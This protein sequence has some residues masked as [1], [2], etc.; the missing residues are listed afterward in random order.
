[1]TDKAHFK[2]LQQL[3]D[4]IRCLNSALL[5][6]EGPSNIYAP[7]AEKI[8]EITREL[9]EYPTRTK[10]YDKRIKYRGPEGIPD[11]IY[12]NHQDLSPVS[13]PSNPVSPY[14]N[15]EMAGE[16]HVSGIARFSSIYEGPPGFVHGGY[17]AAVI[18]ETLGKVQAQTDNP[19]MTSN[20]LI[21]YI[22]PCP[23]NLEYSL[24]GRIIKVEGRRIFTKAS[25]TLNGKIM[26]A[27]KAT[28]VA[29]V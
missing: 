26:A 22:R 7:L 16:Y 27:A 12:G 19:G 11:I 18:D 13:G 29:P 6:H 15:L 5:G 21:Q 3:A 28:F 17:I 8:D 14:V 1:M 9:S 4:S 25:I 24:E 2:N 10:V 20:L 23:I